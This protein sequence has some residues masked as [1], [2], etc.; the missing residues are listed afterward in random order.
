MLT[1]IPLL[2]CAV[3]MYIFND[4]VDIQRMINSEADSNIFLL[5]IVVY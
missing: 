1:K 2:H 3:C 4:S 5:N